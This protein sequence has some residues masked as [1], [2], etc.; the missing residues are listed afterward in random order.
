MSDVTVLYWRDIPAQV[1]VKR[2]RRSAKRILSNRFQEAIDAAAMRAKAIG[3][4]AYLESWR[5]EAHGPAANDLDDTAAEV[6]DRLENDYDPAR[7]DDLI[8]NRGF[9]KDPK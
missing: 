1:V 8:A 4:D 3:T 2:G 9:E 5:R 6:A 7:L